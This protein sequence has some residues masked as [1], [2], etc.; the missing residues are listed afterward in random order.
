MEQKEPTGDTIMSGDITIKKSTFNKLIIGITAALIVAAF[1]G[2]Y[3]VG[4]FG[5][6]KTVLQNI[7][8][9]IPTQAPTQPNAQA[10]IAISLGDSPVKGDPNAPVT[11]VEFS[12]FQCPF[13]GEFY[14]QT[15]PQ[16]TQNYIDS[17]KVK[18]VY[19]NLPLENLHPNARAAALAAECANEQGKFWEYHDMLFESQNSWASLGSVNAT[20]TF[21]QYASQL[22][23]DTNSFNSCVD[24]AKYT[25]KVNKDSQDGTNY[26]ATGTPT[27]FIGNDKKGYIKLVGAQPFS[28]F[29]LE[30]DSELS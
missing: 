30:L 18:L 23:L 13:C 28:A 3:V 6:T 22:G 15:L 17:G 2:G 7:P 14:T 26:G 16:V 11:M 20:N 29:K 10:R 8:A 1:L 5:Q 12:D 27:F 21:K 24:T 25:D 4:N 9:P 19:K